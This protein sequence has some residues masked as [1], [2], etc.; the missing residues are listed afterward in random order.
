[1]AQLVFEPQTHTYRLDGMVIPSV[2]QIMKPLSDAEYSAID[3]AVLD[4]A[5]RRGTAVHAACELYGLYGVA[6]VQPEYQG[7][8]DAFLKWVDQL[9]PTFIYTERAIW[10]KQLLYAG[11]LDLVAE[12]G[13]IKMLVDYKTTSQINDM[14]TKVQ[15]EAYR[16]ALE[17]HGIEVEG[18]AILQLRPNGTFEFRNYKSPDFE[19]WD[20]FT[21]LLKVRGYINKFKEENHHGSQSK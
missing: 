20:V 4:N 16:R 7:Y 2:T 3:P 9:K 17:T 10:H 8:I 13:G 11:T 1:M 5:A 21:S 12:I 6:D 19:A 18:K 15:L 14:L